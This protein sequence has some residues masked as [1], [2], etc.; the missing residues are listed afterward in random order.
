VLSLSVARRTPQFALLGVLGM[1]GGERLRLV[2]AECA[3][4]GLAG[5]ILGLV[6]GTALAAFAL[7]WLAGDLGAGYF[8][9]TGGAAAPL[10]FSIAAALVYGALG[11]AAAVAGG[12][13]PARAAQ[14]LA[15]AQAKGVA[16]AAVGGAAVDRPGAARGGHAARLRTPLGGLPLGAYAAVGACCSAASPRAGDGRAALRAID[17]QS[18]RWRCSR[19]S[20]RGARPMSRRSPSP[21]SSRASRSA[22]R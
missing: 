11:I 14:R 12:W 1:T 2:V 5:S 13:L 22:L 8:Q 17:R 19:S 21:A 3:L 16:L 10:Q 7:R 20:A 6:L 4:L 15:P 18:A 9:A